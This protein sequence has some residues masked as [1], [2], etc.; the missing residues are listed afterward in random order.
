V[1]V[2][3]VVDKLTTVWIFDFDIVCSVR[4]R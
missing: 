4:F 1:L 3:C 2:W